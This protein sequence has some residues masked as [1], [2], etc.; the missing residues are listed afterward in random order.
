M[1]PYARI[2]V[3]LGLLFLRRACEELIDGVVIPPKNGILTDQIE[4]GPL[5]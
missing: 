5:G 2:G 4:R 3:K 1:L